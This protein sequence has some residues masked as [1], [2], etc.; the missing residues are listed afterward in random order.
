M[1]I[2]L[3][4]SNLLLLGNYDHSFFGLRNILILIHLKVVK[5]IRVCEV[6]FYSKFYFYLLF[7]NSKEH[8]N[9]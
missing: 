1:D 8:T 9:L 3:D 6:N 4:S 7:Y 5:I 2:D